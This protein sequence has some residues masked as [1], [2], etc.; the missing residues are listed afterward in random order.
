[1][2][3][4]VYSRDEEHYFELGD[5]IDMLENDGELLRGTVIYEGDQ[6]QRTASHFLNSIADTIQEH[7][8]DQA[9][10]E[11]G[12]FAE[13]WPD[14]PL[15]KRL[16]LNELIGKWL[17][18]NVPVHFWTVRNVHQIEL[19]DEWIAE[20]AATVPAGV[21]STRRYLYCSTDMIAGSECTS[22]AQAGQ[23]DMYQQKSATVKVNPDGVRACV[24]C[25]G[26]ASPGKY[27]NACDTIQPLAGVQGRPPTAQEDRWLREAAKASSTLVAPG[28]LVG[29]VALLPGGND[30]N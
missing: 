22:S 11:A 26:S 12:E 29:G 8:A 28:K 16:E 21:Q 19:T 23:C 30:G 13:D 17:D 3:E 24:N 27:C 14:I 20:N 15:D 5:L 4:K 18:A 25:G 1:M 2:T 10:D 6:V 7:L 9:Y